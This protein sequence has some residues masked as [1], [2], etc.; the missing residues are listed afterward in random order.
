MR[1]LERGI[2]GI[3]GITGMEILRIVA[4]RA[5]ITRDLRVVLALEG[6]GELLEKL[7]EFGGRLIGE[8]GRQADQWQI[9]GLEHG[10]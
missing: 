7:K 2:G 10:G 9:V 4:G 8:I 5:V 1:D 6:F 3:L